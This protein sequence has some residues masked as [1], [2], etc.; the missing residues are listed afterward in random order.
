MLS[1]AISR[2]QRRVQTIAQT[3]A[4]SQPRSPFSKPAEPKPAEPGSDQ[5]LTLLECLVAIFITG[6]MVSL[7]TPPIFIAVASRAQTRRAEQALQVA[8]GEVDR[9]RV[10]VARSQHEISKLPKTVS[11][12]LRSAAPPNSLTSGIRSVQTCNPRYD[13][14]PLNVNQAVQIDVDGDCKPDLFMQVFRTPGSLSAG[15]VLTSNSTP[16]SEKP[17]DF[18]LGIR[19]Y[20]I[21]AKSELGKLKTEPVSLGLTNGEGGQRFQPLA[22]L[23]TPFSWSD[24]SETLCDYFQDSNPKALAGSCPTRTTP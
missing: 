5:G 17:S 15:Q 21:L 9:I 13:N 19:V 10:M 14:S 8:Q 7:I 6:L 1:T 3:I 24:Q 16:G 22:V 23:Y 18:E 12:N 11:G 20:S 4:Q 2:L